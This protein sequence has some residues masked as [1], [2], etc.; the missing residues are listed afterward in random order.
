MWRS[1][2]PTTLAQVLNIET[3]GDQAYDGKYWKARTRRSLLQTIVRNRHSGVHGRRLV[4]PVPARL[5]AELLRPAERLRGPA[6]VG[7][8]DARRRRPP[9]ATSC[10]TGPWYHVDRRAMASTIYP[11]QLAWFD[12]LLKGKRHRD[13]DTDH[14]LHVYELGAGRWVDAKRY[15]LSQA[16]AH[17]LYL[18][19][20]PSER[21][22]SPA[23]SPQRRHAVH[24][25]SRRGNGRRTRSI[26]FVAPRQP[27]RAPVRPVGRRPVALALPDRQPAA[28]PVRRPTTARSRPGRARSPTRRPRSQRTRSR[29]RAVDATIYASRPARRRAR[30]HGRGRRARRHLAT[31]CPAARC[32]APSARSTA[33]RPGSAATP[34]PPPLPPVHRDVADA[35][36]DRHRSPASTSRSS[37][38][39]PRSPRATAC[40]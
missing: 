20:G 36:P 4:R 34:A 23:P 21:R 22:P 3:G 31:R 18:D 6:G 10:S 8:D 35:G 16:P 38:P 7:A 27:L 24:A 33:R 28:Q 14:P 32:S 25:R 26:S 15:P 17:T 39:S 11:L 13:H 29:G 12:H 1:S 2:T 19:G 37:P 5:A 40:G 9:P 30:G